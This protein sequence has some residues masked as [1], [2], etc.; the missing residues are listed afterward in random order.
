MSFGGDPAA[1]LHALL[2]FDLTL[3]FRATLSFWLDRVSKICQ[4]RFGLHSRH[5]EI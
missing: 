2:L 5:D 1:L 4:N 3:V